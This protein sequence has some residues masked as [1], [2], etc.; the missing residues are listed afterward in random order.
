MWKL[1]AIF[2][3]L[4]VVLVGAQKPLPVNGHQQQE[5]SETHTNS[6]SPPAP[7][8][9]TSDVCK[10]NAENAERYAYY[11]AHPKEYLKAAIAPANLA[12]WILAALGVIGGLLALSTL[13]TFKRQTE[14]IV[15]SERAWM[16]AEPCDPDIPPEIEGMTTGIRHVRF[17]VRFK[18][19]GKTPAFLLEIRYS[20]NVLPSKEQL[21]AVHPEYEER[22]IFKWEGGGLPLLPQ[23]NI[24]KNHVNTW[25]KEPVLITRGFDVLWVYGYIKYGDAFGEN[26]E[27]WF[28]Y[29]WV[30]EIEGWQK[31]GFIKGG[32]ESYNRAT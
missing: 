3:L 6:T 2:G 15:T 9:C 13:R 28:C 19:M 4:M 21:P 1:L 10:E 20:G 14:H 12:N 29:R 11:K 7:P 30:E 31:S 18:N 22:E 27:T 8:V 17:S 32:P 23:D 25:A 26:R 24:H 5:H 16:V